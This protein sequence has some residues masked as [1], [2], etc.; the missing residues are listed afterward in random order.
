MQQTHTYTSPVLL[1]MSGITV[2]APS[3]A[4]EGDEEV[5]DQSPCPYPGPPEV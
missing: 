4:S 3:P 5:G 1:I 2:P